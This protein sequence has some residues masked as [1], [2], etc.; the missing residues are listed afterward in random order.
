MKEEKCVATKGTEIEGMIPRRK[1]VARNCPGLGSYLLYIA[2]VTC[3]NN[4][5]RLRSITSRRPL[6]RALPTAIAIAFGNETCCG[7]IIGAI[8]V[9]RFALCWI[10]S[11][12]RK[13]QPYIPDNPCAAVDTPSATDANS[14]S[15]VYAS[16]GVRDFSE[17]KPN[18]VTTIA[19]T[20]AN[21]IVIGESHGPI[22][23]LIIRGY[24]ARSSTPGPYA[25]DSIRKWKNSHQLRVDASRAVVELSQLRVKR[26]PDKAT[27]A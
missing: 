1:K 10:S 11:V 15:G 25:S 17:E 9:T 21:P 14:S 20:I 12:T 27:V 4:S 24:S 13:V 26:T 7:K 5:F 18:R 6:T 3:R 19:L 8:S 2:C 23:A 16:T 22:T